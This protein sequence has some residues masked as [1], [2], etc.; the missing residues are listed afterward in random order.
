MMLAVMRCEEIAKLS[1][2]AD[3]AWPLYVHNMLRIRNGGTSCETQLHREPMHVP[4]TRRLQ[5][6]GRI[7]HEYQKTTGSLG[8]NFMHCR[9]SASLTD[10][11][12]PV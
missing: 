8:K 11:M 12:P 3:S 10:R 5:M 4:N 2:S 7:A 1:E 9:V 6:A